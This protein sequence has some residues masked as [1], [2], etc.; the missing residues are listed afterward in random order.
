MPWWLLPALLAGLFVVTI[1]L[2]TWDTIMGWISGIKHQVP[3]A[4]IA[5]IVR[6]RGL[7]LA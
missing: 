7:W 3:N 5:E 1:A 2:L 6:Q 4:K